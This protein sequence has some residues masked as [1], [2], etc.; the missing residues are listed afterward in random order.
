MAQKSIKVNALLSSVKT[1]LSLIVPLITFPYISRVLQ[2]EA[3]GRH[4]F[5]VSIV[6]YFVLLANL[7]IATY[8]IRE[9]AKLR[10]DRAA[11][12]RFASQIQTIHRISGGISVLLLF[13]V[14]LAVPKLHDYWLFILILGVQIP[15]HVYGKS[16]IYNV[17]EEFGVVTLTQAAFQLLSVVLLLLVVHSPEDVYIYTVTYLISSTGANLFYG[18]RSKKYVD[19]SNVPLQELKVHIKPILIIFST[20]LTITIYVN[21]DVTILGWLVND[22]AVGLYSTSVKVYTIVKNIIDAVITVVIPRLTLYTGSERFKPFF[23]R[24]FNMLTLMILPAMIGLFLLSENVLEII[25]GPEYLEATASL[26]LLSIAMVGSLFGGLYTKGVLLP[27]RQE[28]PFLVATIISA[29]VN[30]VLNFVLIPLFHQTGAAFTTVIAEIIVLLICYRYARKYAPLEKL[31]KTLFSTGVGCAVITGVCLGIKAL[32]LSL[33]PETVLCVA[34]SVVGYCAVQLVL[35]NEV[36]VQT[37]QSVL[38]TLKR[39]GR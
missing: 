20:T 33:Y 27:N 34:V 31:G 37:L 29:V 11:M 39:K 38:K 28:R 12:N 30:V 19:I 21:S 2:V 36:F 4:N 18:A 22:E 35:K 1:V 25:A 15:L 8:A 14:T 9:G 13:A 23:S 3:I 6:G 7:G 5:A 24:V 10:D 32:G 16:W 17:Y 26:R